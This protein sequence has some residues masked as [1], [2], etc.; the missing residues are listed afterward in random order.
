MTDP[1]PFLQALGQALAAHALYAE[2]HPAREKAVAVAW[3]TLGPLLHDEEE[4]TFSF[5]GGDVVH[6]GRVLRELKGWEWATRLADGG[7]ERIEVAR[8]TTPDDFRRF[9]KL[10]HEQARTAGEGRK[11]IDSG[12]LGGI[13]WGRVSLAGEALEELAE[14]VV[15]ASVAYSLREEVEGVGWVYQEA[16]RGELAEPEA[17]TVVRSLALAMRQERRMILPLLELKQFD[18]FTVAHSCNVAVLSMGLA[19]HLGLGPREVRAVGVAALVHDVGKVK[20]PAEILHKPAPYTEAERREVE[21][22][23]T[24]GAKL[25]LSRHHH[26]DLA[27]VVAYEHHRRYDGGG[28]PTLTYPRE[29]HFISRLVAVAEVYDALCTRWPYREALTPEAALREIEAGS[30]SAFD[31]TIVTAFGTMMRGVK[32]QRIP[33]DQPVVL[34]DGVSG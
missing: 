15:E 27:A 32:L 12:S 29:P 21:R 6:R 3:D 7:M 28:Y 31:P 13:R 25:I 2:G 19:E 26:M 16:G 4:A 14:R 30:G 5:L 18:Q 20:V 10:V 9:V 1:V 17:H 22:H 34:V 24:E 23:P 11:A 33:V 8:S